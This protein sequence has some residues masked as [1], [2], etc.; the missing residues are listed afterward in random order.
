[1]WFSWLGGMGSRTCFR[2]GNLVLSRP[3]AYGRLSGFQ[4]SISNRFFKDRSSKKAEKASPAPDGRFL[5]LTNNRGERLDFICFSAYFTL[6]YKCRFLQ[7]ILLP[8][9]CFFLEFSVENQYSKPCPMSF[10][11]VA[12]PPDATEHF[13]HTIIQRGWQPWPAVISMQNT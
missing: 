4:Y 7:T 10:C 11:P 1:M 2:C 13:Q 8:F 12:I 9:F 6:S 5:R 3:P